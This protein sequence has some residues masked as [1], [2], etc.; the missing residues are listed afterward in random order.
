M[1]GSTSASNNPWTSGRMTSPLQSVAASNT[2][3][4]RP[5]QCFAECRTGGGRRRPTISKPKL[6]QRTK[7]CALV[8]PRKST[9]AGKI[10][11][12]VIL[13]RLITSI[14]EENLPEAQC[15]FRPNRSTTDMIFSVR[16]VQEKCIV[17]NMDLIVV[18]TDP[19][20]AFKTVNREACWVILSKLVDQTTFVYLICQF[21][22]DMTGPSDGEA[23]VPS[24][25]LSWLPSSSTCFSPAC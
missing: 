11:A 22:A 10:L 13:N 7:T 25:G 19:T 23:T 17:Q 6:P 5:R 4:G 9:A 1:F 21:L 14:S 16:Q 8:P 18:F 20:K 15:G 12:R 24:K 2:S 3:K